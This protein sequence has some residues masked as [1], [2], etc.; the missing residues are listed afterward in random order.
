MKKR[1]IDFIKENK[2]QIL[3]GLFTFIFLVPFIYSTRYTVFWVDDLT[4]GIHVREYG[5]TRLTGAFMHTVH[6]YKTWQGYYSARFLEDFFNPS[7]NHSYKLL[8]IYALMNI[9]F[10]IIATYYVIRKVFLYFNY[11]KK[12]IMGVFALIIIPFFT[13]GS[14]SEVLYWYTGWMTYSFPISCFFISIGLILSVNQD[15]K[16]WMKAVIYIVSYVL[17]FIACGGSLQISGAVCYLMLMFVAIETY[18]L[19]IKNDTFA[20]AKVKTIKKI[21]INVNT[22]YL[23]VFSVLCSLFNAAAPGNFVRHENVGE[24][25]FNIL[26]ILFYSF[27]IQMDEIERYYLNKENALILFSI[28]FLIFGMITVKEISNYECLELIILSVFLPIVAVFPVVM[29]YNYDNVRPYFPNRVQFINDLLFIVSA[30]IISFCIGKI[31]CNVMKGEHIKEIAI[32]L[33]AFCCIYMTN[34]EKSITDYQPFYVAESIVTGDL[35]D[36]ANRITTALREVE[37]SPDEEVA[38]YYPTEAIDWFSSFILA[39]VP[40]NW[41]NQTIARYYGKK[42]VIFY[43]E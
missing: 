27:K 26:K 23:F 12:Y 11:N 1:V 22:V 35:R 21:K 7:I 5:N 17:T 28:V 20:S 34:V 25:K 18:Y 6:M 14:Y 32:I 31:I 36:C 2:T 24:N 15:T 13:Y 8:R 16:K 38:V 40:N 42:S 19:N 43:R 33:L 29:G 30:S 9:I 10:F 37:E 3:I 39:D 41:V 4:D